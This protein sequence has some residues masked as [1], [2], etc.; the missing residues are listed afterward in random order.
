MIR[1]IGHLS[2]FGK[3]AL[4]I[5]FLFNYRFCLSI[6]REMTITSKWKKKTKKTKRPRKKNE[7]KEWNRATSCDNS[8]WYMKPPKNGLRSLLILW[9]L[10]PPSFSPSPPPPT[11]FT[12]SFI[13]DSSLPPTLGSAYQQVPNM[14]YRKS[15]GDAAGFAGSPPTPIVP[16]HQQY[17]PGYQPLPG[18]YA[19]HMWSYAGCRAEMIQAGFISVYFWP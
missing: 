3:L 9:F 14:N 16:S 6:R 17:P 2:L 18:G 12:E 4:A 5:F 11:S 13:R 8:I 1:T 15:M 10:S 7:T 19:Q